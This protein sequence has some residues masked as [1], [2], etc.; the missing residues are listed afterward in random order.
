MNAGN[1]LLDVLLAGVITFVVAVI[2]TFLYSL[3]AHGT[4]VAGWDTA[5]RLAVILGIVLPL[6]KLRSGKKS[7]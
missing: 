1:F 4:G 5:I 3:I 7:G 6:T 2:V